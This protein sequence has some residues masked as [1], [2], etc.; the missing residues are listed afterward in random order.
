MQWIIMKNL[1]FERLEVAFQRKTNRG[2]LLQLEI[3]LIAIINC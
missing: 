1:E 2:R 3:V